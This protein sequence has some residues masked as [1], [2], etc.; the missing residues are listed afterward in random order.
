M[1]APHSL[2]A[3]DMLCSGMRTYRTHAGA[4]PEIPKFEKRFIMAFNIL[5]DI[6]H[7]IAVLLCTQ[8]MSLV[9]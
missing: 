2:E 8:V 9:N 4:D 6:S 3:F 5:C 1:L 7:C